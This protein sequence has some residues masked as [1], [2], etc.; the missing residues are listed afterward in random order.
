[1][2]N[3]A[4]FGHKFITKKKTCEIGEQCL[5]LNLHSYPSTLT[6]ARLSMVANALTSLLRLLSA[7]TSSI[8]SLMGCSQI[9][10]PGAERL[11]MFRITIGM[12]SLMTGMIVRGCKTFAPKYDCKKEYIENSTF[13]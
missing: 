11:N 2:R 7:V 12:L 1:V 4:L 13:M 9:T 3:I 6:S 5:T 10:V 8:V